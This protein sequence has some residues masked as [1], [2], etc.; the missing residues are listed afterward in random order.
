MSLAFTK[1]RGRVKARL[2]DVDGRMNNPSGLEVD[3]ALA[4]AYIALE[5]DL[6]APTLYTASALTISAG[7]DLFS[8]PVS[9]SGSGYGTGTVEY[10]GQVLIQLQSTGQF[11]EQVTLDQLNA[12]RNGQPTL[13]LQIPNYFAT[14]EDIGNVMRGRAYPGAKD[15]Q[16]CN[17]YSSLS[18]DD[19]RDYVGAGSSGMDDVSANLSREGAG[20]LVAYTSAMLVKR[21]TPQTLE[22]RGINPGVADFWL[23]EAQKLMW[24]EG[25]RRASL[26]SPARTQQWVP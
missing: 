20:A 11:L 21:M 26:D 19:L 25:A 1:L 3:M 8:L 22:E 10:A 13:Q 15:A 12:L 14:Y 9:V 17:L 7:S 23:A 18:A 6:P 4:D 2:R 16:V 5:A 24:Q